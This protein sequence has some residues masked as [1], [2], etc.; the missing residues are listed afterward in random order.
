MEAKLVALG[1]VLSLA[2]AA[3]AAVSLVVQTWEQAGQRALV[4][5]PAQLLANAAAN[6]SPSLGV[7]SHTKAGSFAWA[8]RSK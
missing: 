2:T 8:A 5:G 6:S 4:L 1:L 7:I 3:P